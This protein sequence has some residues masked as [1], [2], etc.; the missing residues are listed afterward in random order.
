[1]GVPRDLN[2]LWRGKECGGPSFLLVTL[3]HLDIFTELMT[4]SLLGPKH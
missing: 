1:M 4:D 2:F 3:T